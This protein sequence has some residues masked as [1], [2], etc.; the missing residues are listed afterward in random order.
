MRM[1]GPMVAMHA[2]AVEKLPTATRTTLHIT[3]FDVKKPFRRPT[4]VTRASISS[5]VLRFRAKRYA[6]HH[7]SADDVR[8]PL[9]R[10]QERCSGE[11]PVSHGGLTLAVSRA[12]RSEGTAAQRRRRL[13]RAVRGHWIGALAVVDS[14]AH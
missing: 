13:N 9:L 6:I 7:C 5:P 3:A 4:V 2:L 12:E 1:L 10:G 11:V 14:H 8:R